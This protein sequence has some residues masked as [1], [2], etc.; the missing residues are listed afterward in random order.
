MSKIHPK[1]IFEA[2]REL[3]T[4]PFK[5]AVPGL[6]S[7]LRHHDMTKRDFTSLLAAAKARLAIHE[8]WETPDLTGKPKDKAPH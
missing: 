3:D 7:G 4:Q 8:V 5:I 1:D 6:A 2:R